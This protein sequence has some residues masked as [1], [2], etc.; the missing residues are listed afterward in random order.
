MRATDLC[1]ANA[2][3]FS[4]TSRPTQG[5]LADE[6]GVTQS[7]ISHVEK[8]QR[9][10]PDHIAAA[11]CS[12]FRLPM[13]FFTVGKGVTD[14]GVH[15]FRKRAKASA[16]DERRVKALFDEAARVFSLGLR[17]VRLLASRLAEPSRLRRRP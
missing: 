8:G 12:K 17:R 7:F 1:E 9:L 11:A 10:L 2:S 16:R 6:L 14:M 15:T 5:D 13:S 4:A 3:R